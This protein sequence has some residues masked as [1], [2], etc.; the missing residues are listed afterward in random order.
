M[1]EEFSIGLEAFPG[2]WMSF[3]GEFIFETGFEEKHFLCHK[4]PWSGSGSGL[5]PD[6]ATAWIRF[7]HGV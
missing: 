7:V 2:A 5:D 1:F 4:Q 6:S 3:V